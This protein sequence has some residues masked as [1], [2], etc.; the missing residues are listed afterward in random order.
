MERGSCKVARMRVLVHVDLSPPKR[1]AAAFKKVIASVERDNL[2]SADMKKLGAGG[3]FYRAKLDYDARLLFRFGRSKGSGGI[4]AFA[5]EIIEKH[6]YERSRFLRGA[7]V[8]EA[9][10][11]SSG[12]A[13]STGTRPSRR[14]FCGTT[15]GAALQAAHIVPWSECAKAERLDPRNGLLLCSTHHALFDDGVLTIDEDLRIVHVDDYPPESC[16]A[17]DT[18]FTQRIHG[19]PIAL[20]EDDRLRPTAN[21]IGRRNRQ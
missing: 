3:K 6:A 1:L 13:S 8:D 11:C 10:L 19:Q 21:Y 12:I 17:A 5:L 15:F 7:T 18:W 16:S 20:P 9:K 4:V 14:S 2:R